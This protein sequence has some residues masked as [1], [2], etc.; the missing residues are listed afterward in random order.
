MNMPCRPVYIGNFEYDATSR[1]VEKLC[2]RYGDL[3][4]VDM[5]TG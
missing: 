5:K 2:E 1:E 4:R 3:Q